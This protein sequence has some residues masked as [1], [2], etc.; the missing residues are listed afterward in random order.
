MVHEVFCHIVVYMGRQH[1][2]KRTSS[3]EGRALVDLEWLRH[4]CLDS[5]SFY[6]AFHMPVVE[7]KSCVVVKKESRLPI[8]FCSVVSA[9]FCSLLFSLHF[10]PVERDF[11]GWLFFAWG[12]RETLYI[13]GRG[14]VCF[15]GMCCCL[16]LGVFPSVSVLGTRWV[17]GGF[18]LIR[19]AS[20]WPAGDVNTA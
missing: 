5:S 7:R 13:S 18:L 14:D 8:R 3:V 9:V 17:L 4:L 2:C 19:H 12:E 6:N 1:K 20:G 16:L 11:F 15:V 10:V